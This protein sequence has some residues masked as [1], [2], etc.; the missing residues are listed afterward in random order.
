[1]SHNTRVRLFGLWVG[2]GPLLNAELEKFDAQGYGSVNGD[3]G[4]TWAPSNVIIVGGQGLNVTGVFNAGNVEALTVDGAGDGVLVK[5]GNF[6]TVAG[7]LDLSNGATALF[8]ANC[9]VTVSTNSWTWASGATPTWLSGSSAT[10][11]AAS[12]LNVNG[13][14]TVAGTLTCTNASTT[15]LHGAVAVDGNVAFGGTSATTFGSTTTLTHSGPEVY[16]GALATRAGRHANIADVGGTFGA[17]NDSYTYSS[18]TTSH[19]VTLRQTAG[20]GNPAATAT[21]RVAFNCRLVANAVVTFLNEDASFVAS[22]PANDAWWIEFEFYSGNWH[23]VKWGA[24]N[25]FSASGGGVAP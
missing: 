24:S 5:A 14:E 17:E 22:S 9:I 20:G 2:V 12:N 4:G 21:M 3:E 15:N 16:S 6:I 1:M 7:E 25:G 23:A 19:T 11:N 13:T 18:L 10:F 8:K